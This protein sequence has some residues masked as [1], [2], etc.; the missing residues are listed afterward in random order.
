MIHAAYDFSQTH[1]SSISRVNVDG[2]RVLLAAAREAGVERIVLVSTIAAFPGTRSLYG[3]AKLEIEQAAI[4][5]GS[6][7]VRPGL[8][9]GAEGAA[10]FGALQRAVTRLPVVPLPAPAD[11]EITLVHET[12]LALLVGRLLESWPAGSGELFVAASQQRLQFADLLDSLAQRAGRHP[13]F[14]RLPWRPVW[15]GLRALEALGVRPP[16][17]SDSLLSLL[18]SDRDPLARATAPA[19]AY[20]VTFRPFQPA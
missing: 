10:V 3:R 13:R 9:W 5:S 6:A 2:S 20:G 16:F 18:A 12:D 4:E 14:L 1:P 8:V 11:F 17:R 15:L 7:I 19:T